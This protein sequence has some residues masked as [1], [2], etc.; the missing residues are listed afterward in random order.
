MLFKEYKQTLPR[1]PPPPNQTQNHPPKTQPQTNQK[2]A[3]QNNNPKGTA[4]EL[5]TG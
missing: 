3:P 4:R 5:Q 1:L 2:Q